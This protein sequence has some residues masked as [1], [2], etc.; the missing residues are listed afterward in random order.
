MAKL[1]SYALIGKEP[2]IF[3]KSVPWARKPITFRRYPIT[4]YTPTTAQ[5]MVRVS[6]AQ[7]AK[8]YARLSPEE[9]RRIREETGLPGASGYVKLR[10]LTV[11]K[12][13]LAPY[14]A[15]GLHRRRTP[16]TYES[17]KRLLEAKGITV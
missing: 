1:T 2:I 16:H 15:P 3:Y 5:A 12:E 6:L 13:E 8:E 10:K 9:K 11:T 7:R 14:R 17:L 4:A